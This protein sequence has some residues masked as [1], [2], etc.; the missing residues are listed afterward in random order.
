MLSSMPL[1]NLKR[2]VLAPARHLPT[3]GYSLH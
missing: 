2:E 3:L 1:G